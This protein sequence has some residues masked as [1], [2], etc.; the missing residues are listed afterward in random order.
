MGP[1]GKERS[2]IVVVLLSII[3]LT[4]YYW[5]WQYALFKEMK[6]HSGA[7]LGGALGV[8]LSFITGGLVG[9]FVLPNEVGELY[10]RSGKEKPVSWLT[11]FWVL[12]PLIGGLIWFAKVQGRLNE[13]WAS[14][15]PLTEGF[16]SA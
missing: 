7:G 4:I 6:E 3:T 1:V 14:V 16:A 11:G 12:I 13:Y 10:T 5:Y 8:I 9:T 15:P 2:W